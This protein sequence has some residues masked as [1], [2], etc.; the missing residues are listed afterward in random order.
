MK[1]FSLLI[2]CFMAMNTVYSQLGPRHTIY[3]D[4]ALMRMVTDEL[5][6]SLSNRGYYIPIYTRCDSASR[7]V[8]TLSPTIFLLKSY[9]KRNEI[10][11]DGFRELLA[12]SI[13]ERRVLED[14]CPCDFEFLYGRDKALGRSA[15]FV[16]EAYLRETTEFI[17]SMDVDSLVSWSF[18]SDGYYCRSYRLLPLIAKRM[19]LYGILLHTGLGIDEITHDD[20]YREYYYYKLQSQQSESTKE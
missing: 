19:L 15:A 2:L 18:N 10:T 13:R 1:K 5:T 6:W 4:T 3:E 20:I 11:D 14:V 9:R 16:C 8:L 17:E 7:T 12:S